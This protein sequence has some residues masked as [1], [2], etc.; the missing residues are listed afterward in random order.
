MLKKQKIL[1][2]G[3]NKFAKMRT[4]DCCWLDLIKK[5]K[6]YQRVI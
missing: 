2:L 4:I 3:L 5:R 1:L 6:K